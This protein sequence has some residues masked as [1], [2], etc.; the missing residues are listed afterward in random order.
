MLPK[1]LSVI[2]N[3]SPLELQ[4]KPS[5]KGNTWYS[6]SGLVPEITSDPEAA[7]GAVSASFNGEALKAGE[8]HTSAPRLYSAGHPKAGQ[9]V[10]GTGGNLTVTHSTQVELDGQPFT[11]M[12]TVT[13]ITDKGFRI[14]AKAMPRPAS[15][16]TI[17]EGISFSAA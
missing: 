2:V 1:T 16:T 3:G 15:T 10:P 8:V 7:L 11:L 5:K 14:S 13:Y 17:I 6:A 9:K 4:G 12:V